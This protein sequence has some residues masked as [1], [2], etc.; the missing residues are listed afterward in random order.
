MSGLFSNIDAAFSGF[1]WTNLLEVAAIAVVLYAALRLLRGTT[2]MTVIRGMAIVVLALTVFGRTLDSVVL[3]WLLDN[4]LAVLFIIVLIVFQPEFR[5]AFEHVGR[6]GGLRSRIGGRRR[7]DE[8]AAA[9]AEAGE[10]LAADAHGALIVVERGTGL[11]ELAASGV[12]VAGEPS[13][14]LICS[15]FQRGSPLHDGAL[16]LRAG[17]VVAARCVVPM[18]SAAMA[19]DGGSDDAHGLDPRLGIRHRAAVAVSAET[20][21]I[22]VVVSE[23]TGTVSAAAGGVLRQGLDRAAL[24]AALHGIR[25][26]DPAGAAAEAEARSGGAA[27]AGS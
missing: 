8:L 18:P 12:R 7:Y 27:A 19:A 5:R 16:L 13:A 1:S 17:E 14:D 21:A 4:G 10:R 2:A 24:E 9:V 6:A 26:P 20:D 23:E 22:A 15:I 25:R 3:D 11:E